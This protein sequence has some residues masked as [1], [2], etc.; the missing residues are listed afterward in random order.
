MTW[1]TFTLGYGKRK[2]R[3]CG[4]TFEPSSA[5]VAERLADPRYDYETELDAAGDIDTCKRCASGT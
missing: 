3:H 5:I 4:R 2:C 1:K